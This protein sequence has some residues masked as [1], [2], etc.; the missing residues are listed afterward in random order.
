[1]SSAWRTAR[2]AIK[3]VSN[4]W[5]LDEIL[6]RYVQMAKFVFREHSGLTDFRIYLESVEMEAIE[7][8]PD[9]NDAGD[10]AAHIPLLLL[11]TPVI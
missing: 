11:N 5:T 7:D 3:Q 10:D 2:C 8:A 6:N 1:M 4:L 9:D